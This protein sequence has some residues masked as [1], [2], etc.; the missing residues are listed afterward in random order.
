MVR[1]LSSMCHFQS[2]SYDFVLALVIARDDNMPPDL[3]VQNFCQIPPDAVDIVT[4]A[5]DSGY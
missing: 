4:A 3:A 1:R 2:I 5:L